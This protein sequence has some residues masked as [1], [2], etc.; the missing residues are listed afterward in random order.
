MLTTIVSLSTRAPHD[1]KEEKGE[2]KK[3]NKLEG[4]TTWDAELIK[5]K[6]LT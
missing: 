4:G 6:F 2:K 5:T 1:W 3:G